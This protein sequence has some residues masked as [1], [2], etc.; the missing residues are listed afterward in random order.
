MST[1]NVSN[2]NKQSKNMDN[3]IMD[4]DDYCGDC[5]YNWCT[6]RGNVSYCTMKSKGLFECRSCMLKIMTAYDK[7]ILL[8]DEA[9]ISPKE[10][11][12]LAV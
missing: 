7:E 10:K 2:R 1:N 8:E 11:L 9:K 12:P 4:S 3:E 5:L 6:K